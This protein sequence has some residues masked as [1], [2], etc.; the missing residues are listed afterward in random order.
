M[1]E[2]LYISSITFLPHCAK[3]K[4]LEKFILHQ[5]NTECIYI[6]SLQF[7]SGYHNEHTQEEEEEEEE[8]K[9]RRRRGR[10]KGGGW[11]EE[12]DDKRIRG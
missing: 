11:E 6:F 5:C 1:L 3:I 2:Q 9:K 12:K 10:K 8:E 7:L 4:Q